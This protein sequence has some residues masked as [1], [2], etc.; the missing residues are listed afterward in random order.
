[1][2]QI[3]DA[4][5]GVDGVHVGKWYNGEATLFE[6]LGSV[7]I[8]K[9]GPT[10]QQLYRE[11]IEVRGSHP[12]LYQVHRLIIISILLHRVRP[13]QNLRYISIEW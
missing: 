7:A 10:M 11:M 9:S 1:M 4:L 8:S 6:R 12:M 13:A 3:N 5:A 2:L